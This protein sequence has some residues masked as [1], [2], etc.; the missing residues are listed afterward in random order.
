MKHLFSEQVL[1]L[2]IEPGDKSSGL[3][4][5]LHILVS[6]PVNELLFFRIRPDPEIENQAK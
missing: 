4:L 1:F 5:I 2:W 3:F 6:K